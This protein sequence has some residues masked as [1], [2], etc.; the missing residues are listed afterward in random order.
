MAT[1]D[2][3]ALSRAGGESVARP[4]KRVLTRVVVPAAILLGAVGLLAYAARESLR[5]AVDV[6]VAPVVLVNGAP[7]ANRAAAPV[8]QVV[9]APG[10]IEAD[11][12]DVG[13]P[14][15]ATG[16]LKELLVLEGQRVV[17][18]EVVAKLVDEDAKLAVARAEAA[19]AEA[20]AGLEQARGNLAADEAKSAEIHDD[21]NRKQALAKTG[22]V[23]E[24]EVAQLR[25][26]VSSHDSVCY[27]DRS[28]VKRAE[29]ET[30]V[31]RVAL[32]EAKLNLD[33]MQVRAPMGGVVL[34]RLVVPG[35][36][37]MPDANNPFAG[38]V[39]R[40]YDPAHLQVRVDVPLVDAAK[41]KVGDSAEITTETLGGRKFSGKVTRFV[42]EA[43][44]QKNT[45]QVK[46][47]I[48]DPAP[49]LKPEMLAKARISTGEQA[50]EPHGGGAGMEDMPGMP[51]M[52]APVESPTA[53]S[54]GVVMVPKAALVE[55]PGMPRM[56]WVLDQQTSTAEMRHLRLGSE[57]GDSV[58]VL[59][60]LR[61][62]DRVLVNPPASIKD[63]VKVRAK[64]GT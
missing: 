2:L 48:S 63:G 61:P 19:V 50:A 55:M 27:A 45:V 64:E 20:D 29:A 41:V 22:A 42:H 3:T 11:P 15:L 28:A 5:P 24:G 35:Q 49:E 51:G 10:W 34:A 59:E 23:S 18:G 9:Q 6:T 47:S 52:K 40:L 54:G 53:A 4:R 31:A 37:L 13:V 8:G 38:V 58:E 14:A 1:A 62:G 26:R 57:N 17:A 56:V 32:D 7:S 43:N 16:V 44:V 39:V 33:R 36:R 21:F 46:V 12:Y 60:G 30:R 25:L